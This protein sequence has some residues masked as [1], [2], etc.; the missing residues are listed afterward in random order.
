M[1]RQ[2]KRTSNQLCGLHAVPPMSCA[3][4]RPLS[5][6]TSSSTFSMVA[7]ATTLPLTIGTVAWVT[8]SHERTCTSGTSWVEASK[9]ARRGRHCVIPN[10]PAA[11][12]ALIYQQVKPPQVLID[13][14]EPSGASLPLQTRHPTLGGLEAKLPAWQNGISAPNSQQKQAAPPQSVQ[15]HADQLFPST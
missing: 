8:L 6:T 5:A 2:C 15:S 4:A 7:G 12:L 11:Q 3:S 1:E 14:T 10:S 9:L 13:S